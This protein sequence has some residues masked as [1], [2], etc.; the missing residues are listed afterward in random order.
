MKRFF[1][2]L[3]LLLFSALPALSQTRASQLQQPNIIFILT[4]DLGY[5]DL[6]VFF[7]NQRQ[8]LADRREPWHYTPHLD[9]MAASGAQL[10]QQYANAPVCAPSR[11][12]LLTGTHQGNAH[13]RNNQFDKALENNHTLGTVL[14]AAGYSTVAI[15]KW[16]LQGV[17]EVGPHWPAHPLKRGFDAFFGYM[18]HRDGHEHYPVEGVYGGPK[19]VWDGYE[20]VAATLSKCYTTDLWTAKAK[21]YI[22]NHVQGADAAKP[23]FMYLAYDAPH[24]VLELPTQEYP[25]GQGL[26]GGLQWVGTPGHLI[27]T[28]SGQVDSYVHPDYRNATYDDDRNPATTETAWPATYKR[29]ATAVRRIDDGVGDLLQLLKDLQ[30]DENTLV[31]F[32]SDNGPSLESYLPAQYVPNM[33][34]FFDSFGPFD[35]IKRDCWEGGLRMPTLVSWPSRIP[36]GRVVTTPSIFSDWLPTLADV[37]RVPAP[38]RTDGV[39][40]LP[41]L[42][43]QGQQPASLVYVEYF[44]EGKTPD[45]QKV[46]LNRRGR[47]REQMQ[48]LRLGDLVGVRYQVAAASDDFE[49]YDVVKDPAQ[50]INL[51]RQP[52]YEHLQQQFKVKALQVR[53][54]NPT[55]KR[56]YDDALI[57]AVPAPATASPGFSWKYVQGDFPWVAAESQQP[58]SAYGTTKV[59]GGKELRHKQGMVYYTGYLPVPADGVYEFSLTTTGNAFVRLHEAALLD[60]DFSYVAGTQLTQRAPLQAGL[61]PLRIAYL[62]SKK[63]A[64]YLTLQW[65]KAGES[66]WRPLAPV[67]TT[68]QP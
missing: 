40:L 9:R 25:K 56:P 10:T 60:A 64:S 43:G 23:F 51:A 7:Q 42:T 16:G 4:D 22:T 47:K 12:S 48:L 39:S 46:E 68:G 55:A 61:H 3:T 50:R 65:R 37:A 63:R 41:S 33:P 6:G 35:G 49:L 17:D 58:A 15:G 11:A 8:Q 5:G 2:F 21:K 57:S 27:T 32:T 30:L 36:T 19:Q 44:E 13:V 26:R 20:N 54:A 1:S 24:A 18:R 45:Y 38:A 59:V 67:M 52:G 14:Q 53:H 29:Y 34:T 31:V 66:I 28:A 62:G